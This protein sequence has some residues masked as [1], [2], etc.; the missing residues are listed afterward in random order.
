MQEFASAPADSYKCMISNRLRPLFWDTDWD[1][2]DPQAFPDYTIF[3]VL[4]Y[5]DEEAAV[6]LRKTFMALT[7]PWRR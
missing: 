5:G 2:F 1:A 3:R 4:E 6:G 7:G